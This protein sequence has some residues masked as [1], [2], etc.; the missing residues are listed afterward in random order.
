VLISVEWSAISHHVVVSFSQS[1]YPIAAVSPVLAGGQPIGHAP[2]PEVVEENRRSLFGWIA[3]PPRALG[4]SAHA[5]EW[6]I[7]ADA[8]LLDDDAESLRVWE[9][10]LREDSRKET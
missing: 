8:A 1:G 5:V 2:Y 10:W 6:E 3:K 7:N 4:F 9:R